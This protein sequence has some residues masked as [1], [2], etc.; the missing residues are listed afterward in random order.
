M[1]YSS[2]VVNKLRTFL[3]LLGITIGIFAII[4]VFTVISSLENSIRTSI[5]S[6]GDNVVYIQK[7]PW[8]FDSNYPWWK[9]LNRPVPKLR[10][11]DEIQKRSSKAEAVAFIASTRQNLQFE[12]TQADRATVMCVSHDYEKIWNFELSDGRYFSPFESSNGNNIGIIGAEI[13]ENLFLGLDPVGRN[14]KI[15]GNRIK[16]IG[17]FKKEGKSIGQTL[18]DVVILPVS[19]ARTIF[20]VRSERMDPFIMAKAKEGVLLQELIDELK[21]IMR[22]IRKLKPIA[23]DNFAMNKASVFIAKFELIFGTI[24]MAGWIIG[25]FSILVGAFGIANIMF[26]SVRERTNIIGI[27]KAMGAKNYFILTQF[28]FEAVI[29]SILGGVIGLLLIYIGTIVANS[30]IDWEFTLTLANITRGLSISVVVGVIAGFIPAWVA[31]RLNP[32]EAI[33]ATV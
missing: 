13:A 24:N 3:S 33:Q 20:D 25:G 14:I 22:G 28:L 21:G 16:V 2:L 5:E 19:F 17:V 11:L 4:S 1:A 9:Y 23:E 12:E 10:E 32:V 29:L 6:L 26:V 30:Q 27:Q 7:W 15:N 8:S 31:S 18:D